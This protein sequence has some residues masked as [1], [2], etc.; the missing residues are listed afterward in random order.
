[1]APPPLRNVMLRFMQQNKT[2]D[3][4]FIHLL[5]TRP[6]RG[7]G[8][9]ASCHIYRSGCEPKNIYL[10]FFSMV[11]Y[12]SIPMVI[13]YCSAYSMIVSLGVSFVHISFHGK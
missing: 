13:F 7:G 9:G 3:L 11:I 2:F 5:A 4:K 10:Y 6:T 8:G 12:P 1:M